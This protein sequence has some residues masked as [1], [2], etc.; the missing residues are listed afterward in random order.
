MRI[1]VA[2][3]YTNF[4]RASLK[5]KILCI[6]HATANISVEVLVCGLIY[7]ADK[8]LLHSQLRPCSR[9]T[10]V[11]RPLNKAR[12]V[13]DVIAARERVPA[14]TAEHALPSK[15]SKKVDSDRPAES[16]VPRGCSSLYCSMA[17]AT[18][19]DK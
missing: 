12:W 13:R 10:V 3:S 8:P 2:L 16:Q 19:S 4:V 17:F 15:T 1:G 6:R 5:R 11:F 7:D 18:S 9:S 14:E